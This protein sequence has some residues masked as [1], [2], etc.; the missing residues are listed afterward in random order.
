M[1]QSQLYRLFGIHGYSVNKNRGRGS[2]TLPVCRAAA[3][4]DLLLALQEQERDSSREQ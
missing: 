1:S 2:G 3:T 4:S